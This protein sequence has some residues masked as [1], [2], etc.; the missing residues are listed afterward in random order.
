MSIQDVSSGPP[1][2]ALIWDSARRALAV[3]RGLMLTHL[4]YVNNVIQLDVFWLVLTVIDAATLV[5]VVMS[6]SCHP[7]DGFLQSV[8]KARLRTARSR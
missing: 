2:S 4:W 7:L 1:L 3:R 8:W 5:R 6:I